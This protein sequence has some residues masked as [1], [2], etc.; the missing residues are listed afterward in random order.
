LTRTMSNEKDIHD[1]YVNAI[2][3]ANEFIYIE[4]QYFIGNLLI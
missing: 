2:K 3:N 1:S 4:N